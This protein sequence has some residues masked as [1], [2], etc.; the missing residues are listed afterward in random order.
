MVLP[1]LYRSPI[2]LPSAA[3]PGPWGSTGRWATCARAP[4]GGPAPGLLLRP[5]GRAGQ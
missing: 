4:R 3:A 2:D 5:P 1:E